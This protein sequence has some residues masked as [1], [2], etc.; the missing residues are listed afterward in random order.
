MKKWENLLKIIVGNMIL[1]FSVNMFILPFEFIAYGT[2]GLGLIANHFFNLPFN[3]V[4]TGINVFMFVLGLLVL[5]KRFAL[6][7]LLSTMIYPVFL[8]MTANVSEII[9]E[10]TSS[11]WEKGT[12][13]YKVAALYNSVL[14]NEQ[15]NKEGI[16]PIKKYLEKIDNV[17]STE[18]LTEVNNVLFDELCVAPFMNF[19]VYN[20]LKDSTKYIIRFAASAPRMEKEFYLEEGEKKSNRKSWWWNL[21]F[22]VLGIIGGYFVTKFLL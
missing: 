18:E 17:S 15:R 11:K 21:F 8:E 14:D 9:K 16:A 20:D 10:I 5:G 3:A 13:E 7:T 2:T 6:T 22:C 19:H 4:V 12:P 1:A